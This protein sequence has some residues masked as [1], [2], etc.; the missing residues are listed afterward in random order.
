[1]RVLAKVSRAKLCAVAFVV[2]GAACIALAC[3]D[4]PH[5]RTSPDQVAG[6]G[7]C[8]AAVGQ[9]PPADCDPSEADCPGGGCQIDEGRCGKVS[10]C[11]PL[12]DNTGKDVLDFRIRR[13]NVVAPPALAASFVRDNILNLN[14]DLKE[15][16]CGEKG[17]GLFTWLI[18]LDKKAGTLLTGGAPPAKDPLGQGFCFASFDFNGT[19]VEPLSAKISVEG[20]KV[21]LLEQGKNVNI[22]IF[23]KDDLAS[24]V[25]LP[26][27][28][29]RIENV[30]LSE[31]GNCIG[32]YNADALGANC[33]E[34]AGLCAKWR[35]NGALGGYITLEE[36]DKVQVEL[37]G[38]S[39][40]AFLASAPKSCP[41]DGSGKISYKGDFCSTDKQPGS[42]ADSVWLAAT[43][44][45]SAAKIFDGKG[46]VQGCSGGVPSTDAGTDAASDA[47]TDAPI[48][49]PQD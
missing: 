38:K 17:Q 9:L 41:R 6:G 40:C 36:A 13:L 45:A 49:A 42:C 1:M 30:T 2:G 26:L 23:V 20:Q 24:A 44:A 43:F 22:P 29:V 31:D 4:D 32:S 15:P 18:R 8:E 10:S 21:K 39:L 35:T 34:Q 7:A 5:R 47:A 16:T 46:I 14:I 12:S 25:L 27:S 11:M 33:T 37:L 19:K 28:G 48:D 3:E